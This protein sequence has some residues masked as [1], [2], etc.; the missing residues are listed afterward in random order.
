MLLCT[1]QRSRC[2][3]TVDVVKILVT[4]TRG[5]VYFIKKGVVS[6]MDFARVDTYDGSYPALA[7][8]VHTSQSQRG[9]RCRRFHV[10][11]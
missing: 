3:E 4:G 10:D 11:A 7:L 8:L 2:S 9:E 5:R 6:D 1:G